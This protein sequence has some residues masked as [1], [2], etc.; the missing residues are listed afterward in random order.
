MATAAMRV[1]AMSAADGHGIPFDP[2]SVYLDMVTKMAAAEL[3]EQH[4]R[5]QQQQEAEA[6]EEKLQA[7]ASVAAEEANDEASPMT[8]PASPPVHSLLSTTTS[9]ASSAPRTPLPRTNVDALPQQA[10]LA[11]PTPSGDPQHTAFA[12]LTPTGTPLQQQQEQAQVRMLHAPPATPTAT[13]GP[14]Q[15]LQG[16]QGEVQGGVVPHQ[17][18]LILSPIAASSAPATALGYGEPGMRPPARRLRRR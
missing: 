15:Q 14:Q 13:V 7:C 5:W 9:L 8:D 3:L 10:A 1:V 16:R 18:W 2:N 17:P 12:T 11:T 4:T 6:E